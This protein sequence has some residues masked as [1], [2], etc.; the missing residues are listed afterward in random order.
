MIKLNI[1]TSFKS[2]KPTT[3]S[4]RQV[5]LLNKSH[6]IKVKPLKS[7]SSGYLFGNGR[8][9]TGH[10]TAWHRGKSHKRLYRKIDFS[11]ETYHGIVEGFEY[12]PNRTPWITRI[13]NPDTLKHNY[14]LG[15]KSL[16][17]GSLVS[18]KTK[19]K[20]KDGSNF[21][22][23]NLPSGF[24]I[25][26]LSSG[27]KKKGQYLRAAG[28]YGMLIVKTKTI[29]RIKLRSGEHRLFS[30]KS[31]ATLGSVTNEES[32]FVNLGKAGRN[33]WYGRRPHVRGVAINPVDHPH[34]GGEGRTSGGRPSVTP[35]GKPTKGKPTVKTYSFLRLSLRKQ[36]KK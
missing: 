27:P 21:S 24:V 17:P 9:N 29:A 3:P 16:V 15:V 31:Q 33:R 5:K 32:K 7:R 25:H 23:E 11:R 35:W 18:P 10:I 19:E 6:L 12:D 4:L 36:K 13:F 22:L 14:V 20:I 26:N 8:N 30:L 2:F 28:V 34:G 1:E